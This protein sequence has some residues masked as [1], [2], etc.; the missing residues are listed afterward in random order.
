MLLGGSVR[1]TSF[2][3]AIGRSV[4]DLPI[5]S[6]RSLLAYWQKTV[7]ELAGYIGN[8]A[9]GLEGD[10]RPGSGTVPQLPPD[11][12]LVQLVVERDR[13]SYRGSGGVLFDVSLSHSDDDLLLVANAGQLYEESLVDLTRELASPGADVTIVS[14]EDGSPSGWMLVRSRS[15]ARHRTLAEACGYE[16]TNAATPALAK[17]LVCVAWVCNVRLAATT[18]A[19]DRGLYRGATAAFRRPQR[20]CQRSG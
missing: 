15:F 3:T 2:N 12:P 9:A 20:R 17:K 13:G 8:E 5:E 11:N 4:L 16:G 1:A 14:H 10:D 18:G 19:H 6:G 7:G